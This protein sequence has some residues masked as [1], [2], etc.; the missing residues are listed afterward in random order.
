[1]RDKAEDQQVEEAAK[2]DIPQPAN[3][4]LSAKGRPLLSLENV[5]FEYV[6]GSPI[7]VGVN[8]SLRG[9]QRVVLIGRNGCGKSTLM[10]LIDKSLKATTGT[11]RHEPLVKIESLSQHSVEALRE[12]SNR[13]LTPIELLSR[14]SKALAELETASSLDPTS[15]KTIREEDIRKHLA[16]FGI[17]N[18]TAARTTLKCLSGGQAVRVAFSLCTW[19]QSPDVLLLDEPTNHLDMQTIEALSLALEGFEGAAVV[20]SH[21][22]AFI[23]GL[24]SDSVF[25]VSKKSRTLVRLENGVDE[26]ISKIMKVKK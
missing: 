6:K 24:K 1:M 16:R 25:M 21:D 8:L 2:W 4:E 11:I 19:P 26:Y 22:E 7:L 13:D 23:R 9:S 17:R 18:D 10:Q 5:S 20:V 12:E 3:V 14:K 15:V